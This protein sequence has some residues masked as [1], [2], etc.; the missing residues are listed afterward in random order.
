MDNYL[1]PIKD[2]IQIADGA[3]AFWF[4][5]SGTD[6]DWRAGQYSTFKITNPQE[7]DINGNSRDFSIASSPSN[8][9][10]FI[11]ATRM[12]N[13]AFKNN[14]KNMDLGTRLSVKKP[15]GSFALHENPLRPAVFIAGGMGVT[16][17]RSIIEWATHQTLSHQIYLFYSNKT[18]LSTPFLNDFEKWQLINSNFKF[19]PTLT[20]KSDSSWHGE[21]GQVTIQ[22]IERYVSN[23]TEPIYYII[24]SPGM[25]TSIWQMLVT[26]GINNDDIKA[27]EFAGY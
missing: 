26:S 8:K 19:I 6:F 7:T 17:A 20:E 11:I 15:M 25:V 3:M 21:N 27:E 2:K 18:K 22:M 5:I 13:T 1:L 12:R 23:D 9:S 4:D 10:H 14:L 24:G 16:P